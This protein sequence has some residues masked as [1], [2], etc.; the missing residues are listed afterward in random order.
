MPTIIGVG[1]DVV[2]TDRL[3]QVLARQGDRFEQRVYG[4]RELSACAGR[5]DRVTALASSFAA[6]EAFLKALGTG[7]TGGL[8]LRQVEV[9]TSNGG[10]PRVALCG[11]TAI[12]ARERG[13]RRVHLGLGLEPGLAAA[14]VVL[15]GEC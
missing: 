4:P 2:E 14:V 13:V 9:V 6:K 1:L 12:R 10:V 3:A 15:E 8:S 5:G 7:L 11:V